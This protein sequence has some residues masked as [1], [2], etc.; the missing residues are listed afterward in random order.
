MQS[1]INNTIT[2]LHHYVATVVL[3]SRDRQEKL[4]FPQLS[5]C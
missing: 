4:W 2:K 5:H 1:R 3:N